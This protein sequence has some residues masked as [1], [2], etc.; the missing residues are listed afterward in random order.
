MT[1]T[2]NLL[3]MTD[4]EYEAWFAGFVSI[5]CPIPGEEDLV[6]LFSQAMRTTL[7]EERAQSLVDVANMCLAMADRVLGAQSHVVT[8]VTLARH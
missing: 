8:C 1:M 6:A 2:E 5:D 3:Q 4:A 7:P